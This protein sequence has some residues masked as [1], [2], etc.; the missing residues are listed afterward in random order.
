M[1]QN[2][3]RSAVVSKQGDSQII[4]NLPIT[5]VPRCNGSNAK[6]I[7]LKHLQFPGMEASGGRPEGARILHYWTYK[8]LVQQNSILDGKS[9]FPV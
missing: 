8:L 7:R 1:S 3:Q 2:S 9:T 5:N 6:T 4:V